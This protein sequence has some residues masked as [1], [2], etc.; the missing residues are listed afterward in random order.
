[1]R[2]PQP[3][4]VAVLGAGTMGVMTAWRL[5]RRAVAVTAFDDHE[6]GHEHGAAGGESRNFRLAYKEGRSYVPLLR[7]AKALWQD[8]EGESGR[9]LLLPIG[10]L[11]IGAP[12]HPEVREAVA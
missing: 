10:A 12:G 3:L 11:T 1:M 7:Q 5:A 8:L 4:R 2:M 9:R 6:P